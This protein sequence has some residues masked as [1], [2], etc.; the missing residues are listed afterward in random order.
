MCL[1]YD[2]VNRNEMKEQMQETDWLL[3]LTSKIKIYLMRNM[4][5]KKSR[6]RESDLFGYGEDDN[7]KKKKK[8]SLL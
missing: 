2:Y 3:F 5:C 6:N 8:L 4:K 7:Q 1:C